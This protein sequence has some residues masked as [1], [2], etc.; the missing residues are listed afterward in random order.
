MTRGRRKGEFIIPGA[1]QQ[2]SSCEHSGHTTCCRC[3][4][5]R[6]CPTK[7]EVSSAIKQLGNGKS[8][9]HDSIPADS[10]KTDSKTSL[11]I[12]YPLFSKIWEVEEIPTELKEERSLIA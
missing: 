3:S 12:L 5:N 8:A 10:L 9:G 11:N 7:K 2:A 1:T 6:C 4:V